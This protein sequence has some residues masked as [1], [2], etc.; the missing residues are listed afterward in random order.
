MST[1]AIHIVEINHLEPHPNADKLAI[2]HIGGWKSIVQLEQ[3]PLNAPNKHRAIFIEPDYEVPT[4]LAEFAFLTSK[5]N[6]KTGFARIRAVR[7]RGIL[8][9]GLVIPVPVAL[10]HME[11]G[12]DVMNILGIRRYEPPTRENNS[13]F[14]SNTAPRIALAPWMQNK[15]DLENIQNYPDMLLKNEMVIVTEKIHGTNSRFV[16]HDDKFWCGS[17]NLW[18]AQGEDNLYTRAL[19]EHMKAWLKAF[20]GMILYGEIYGPGVQELHY[21]VK[22]PRF[23]AFAAAH[24]RKASRMGG[25]PADEIVWSNTGPL[26]EIL[27]EY[28][29]PHVPVLYEGPLHLSMYEATAEWDSTLARAHD[30]KSKQLSEG[31]VITPQVEYTANYAGKYDNRLSFK[32]V[33]ERYFAS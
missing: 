5:A 4:E 22:E 30:P 23:I 20:P 12:S 8:S 13:T 14:I 19:T 2:A 6:K 26:F 27:R 10:S 9:Y 7:L 16:Y 33:S 28:R 3:F 18:C 25:T 31:V 15:F 1:H 17:R 24:E 21:G 11:T 29:I 32:F